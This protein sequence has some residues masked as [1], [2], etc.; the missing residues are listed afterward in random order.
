MNV[1]KIGN[2]IVIYFL[3]SIDHKSI[4]MVILTPQALPN[5]ISLFKMRDGHLSMCLINLTHLF[6]FSKNKN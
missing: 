2:G 3:R 5:S 6:L 1:I 4:E